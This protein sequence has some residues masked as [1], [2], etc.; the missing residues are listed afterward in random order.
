M[1]LTAQQEQVLALISAGSSI[2]AAAQS[3]GIHRNTIYNWL[4]S[5]TAFRRDLAAARDAKAVYWRDQAE[6]HAAAAIE[7]IRAL[8]TDPNAPASVRLKAAQAILNLAI[9]LPPDSVHNF[10]QSLP[11]PEPAQALPIAP[12]M[13]TSAQPVRTTP[14]TGR[15]DLCPC[16]SGRKFKRCCL[17]K[18]GAASPARAAAA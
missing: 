17:D 8:M 16:G 18:P 11:E 4:C 15:N 6:Q 12:I 3:V 10:A 14:K 5:A 7:T 1:P 9:T 2:T 13:H